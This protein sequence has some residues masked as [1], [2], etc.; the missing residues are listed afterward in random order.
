MTNEQNK[1]NDDEKRESGIP[2]GGQGRVDEVGES[3][4]YP[5]SAMEGASDDAVVHGGAS[6]GQGERGAKGYED[7]GSSEIFYTDEELENI[8]KEGGTTEKS[9]KQGGG[10]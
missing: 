10:K 6:L 1:Q 8:R 3:G 7:S 5:V 9:N 4:V 2:G